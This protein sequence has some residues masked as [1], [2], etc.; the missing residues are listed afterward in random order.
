MITKSFLSRNLKNVLNLSKKF[1]SSSKESRLAVAK[2]RLAKQN[3]K[4]KIMD[5]K[6]QLREIEAENV[7]YTHEK[8]YKTFLDNI[9]AKD[10]DLENAKNKYPM[11]K[12]L[13]YV[14]LKE[15]DKKIV[16]KFDQITQ[17]L[18]NE[19][20]RIQLYNVVKLLFI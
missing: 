14:P 4:Q 20:G 5:I 11:I 16:A 13:Y 15:E 10:K 3:E 1:T 18:I 17:K 8:K 6:M 12:K 19:G 7:E 2:R 9:C